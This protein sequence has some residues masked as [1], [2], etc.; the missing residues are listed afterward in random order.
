LSQRVRNTLIGAAVILVA[1]GAVFLQYYLRKQDTYEGTV[2]KK[3]R[4]FDLSPSRAKKILTGRRRISPYDYDYFIEVKT[5]NGKV[6]RKR[7]PHTDYGR[8]KVG[9]YVVKKKGTTRIE[10][11]H[12]R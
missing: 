3:E 11:S 4:V 5:K 12:P 2:V 7:I 9:D 6:V 8:V 1:A 10:I